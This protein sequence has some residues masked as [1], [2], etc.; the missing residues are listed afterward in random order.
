MVNGIS[1][2]TSALNGGFVG[3]GSVDSFEG[4]PGDP[5]ASALT[6][7]KFIVYPADLW[8]QIIPFYRC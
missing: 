4:L 3:T 1:A 2:Y 5:G 6:D 7:Q 8:A